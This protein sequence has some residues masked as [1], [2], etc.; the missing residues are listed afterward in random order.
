MP[1]A[2]W[3]AAVQGAPRSRASVPAPLRNPGPVRAGDRVALIAPAGPPDPGAL[4]RACQLIRDWDLEPVLGSHVRE[5]DSRAAYLAGSDLERAADLRAAWLDGSIRAVICLRGG[6]GSMRIIDHLDFAELARAV[7]KLLVGS[8]DITALHQAWASRLGLATLFAPMPA[9]TDLLD[10]PAARD[11]L[12]HALFQFGGRTVL[13]GR[14]AEAVVEG[15]AEGILVG[16]NLSLVAAHL[17]SAEFRL[18]TGGIGLL[19]EIHEEPYRLDLLL[20][21]LKRVGWFEALS[22]LAFGSWED[23]GDPRE[24]KDLLLE[25]SSSLGIPTIWNLG[26]GHCAHA[27]SIP[28]GC[29]ATLIADSDCPR[30]EVEQLGTVEDL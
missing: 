5:R 22:G 19:E 25:Y 18:P 8:S 30:I 24:V 7:P 17:G 10:D 9:T 26:F 11:Q 28:L 2:N 3:A 6:Y 13:A 20:L 23:C 29:P 14:A 15:R 16:G 27:L 1:H 21:E 4:D 12:R